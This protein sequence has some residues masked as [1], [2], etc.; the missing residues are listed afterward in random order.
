MTSGFLN[1]LS[2]YHRL[3]L[4]LRL[5]CALFM[6]FLFASFSHF[7][8]SPYVQARLELIAGF[9]VRCDVLRTTERCWCRTRAQSKIDFKTDVARMR[10]PSARRRLITF[11]D[12]FHLRSARSSGALSVERK[13]LML[14]RATNVCAGKTEDS[15]AAE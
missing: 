5:F 4:L 15:C 9:G 14:D 6:N 3:L 13:C 7:S 11:S 1:I 8:V 10:F 12:F 2:L